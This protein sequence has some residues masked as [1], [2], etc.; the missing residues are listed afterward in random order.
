[1]PISRVA[2]RH[3]S[4]NTSSTAVNWRR[5]WAKQQPKYPL[6]STTRGWQGFLLS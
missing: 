5:P 2:I 1:L 3:S 6:R 4:R